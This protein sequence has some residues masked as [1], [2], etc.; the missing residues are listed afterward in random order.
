MRV[1][2]TEG[3]RRVPGSLLLVLL[4]ATA[5]T[6]AA[7]SAAGGAGSGSGSRTGGKG[8]SSATRD[9]RSGAPGGSSS[10]PPPI[11]AVTTTGLL[12]V[13]D[14][15][16]GEPER[17]LATN[18]TGDEVSVSR[19]SQTVYFETP[20]GCDH[21]IES[22][23]M[24]GGSTSVVA[25]GMDPAVSPD[26]SELA[27][28]RQ[29][30]LSQPQ[31]ATTGQQQS[32]ASQIELVVRKLS[33]GQETTYPMSPQALSSGLPMPIDHLSWAPDGQRI[34]VSIPAVQDN[35]GWQ[36]VVLDTTTASYYVGPGTS[37]V[38]IP[39][40]LPDSYYRE[41]VFEPDGNLFVNRVCCAGTPPR[42][43]SSL[44]LNVDPSTGAEL[45][46]IAIG[47]TD[48]DHTSLDV[49]GS[50]RWILY[51]SGQNLLVSHDG[52][53]PTTLASGFVAATW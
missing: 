7:C 13:L 43:V 22:V 3:S 34:A 17:T 52:M 20:E 38:P 18:A 5:P 33:T 4:L 12:E 50:G 41:G 15:S 48:V 1:T 39:E 19:S 51:L 6:V 47:F 14:P 49:D 10:S 32:A 28:A 36:L 42:R 24:D 25:T 37:Q 46:E 53:R 16:T 23:P 30:D 8:G 27:Y 11:V 40:S 45:S 2:R 21:E 31:C 29:P 9:N 26:G 35:E 44:L